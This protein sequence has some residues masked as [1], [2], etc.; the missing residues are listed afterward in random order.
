MKNIN[1]YLSFAAVFAMLFTSCSKDE[2]GVATPENENATLS[3]GAIVNDLVENRAATKS[4]LSG[5]PEC[6]DDATAD[7]VHVYLVRVNNDGTTTPVVGTAA[8]PHRVDLVAGEVFTEEDA[9]LELT[10]GNYRLE[11]FA[12]YDE[13]E[14][15]DSLIWLAPRVGSALGEYVDNALPLDIDLRAGVKKYVDVSVLCFDNRD[16]NEYGYLFFELDTNVAL[17][18]C[19]FANFCNDEGMHYTARYS[20]SIWSGTNANG[21]PLYTN[22]VNNTGVH[23]NGDFYATPLCFA[24][25][26][27]DDLNE[28]YLYYEITLLDWAENYGD[29]EQVT[30][31]GT[32]TK[33]DILN[34]FG[35]D[36]EDN[37][38]YDHVRFGCE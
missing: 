4:H 3:F 33:Q 8:T 34:N 32:I 12:V 24:L 2:A 30:Q 21:V 26:D 6:N 10:P 9:A 38:E 37:V 7:Y 35:D 11:H 16:V 31:S 23:D 27:N 22:V 14:G 5:I 17:T 15:D 19:F 29:V 18:Y 36:D 25:P 20:V 1:R 28:E 13:M